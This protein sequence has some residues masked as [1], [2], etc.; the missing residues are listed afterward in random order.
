MQKEHIIITLQGIPDLKSGNGGNFSGKDELF[1]RVICHRNSKQSNHWFTIRLVCSDTLMTEDVLGGLLHN[2]WQQLKKTGRVRRRLARKMS[3]LGASVTKELSKD[4]I[5]IM[6]VFL[7]LFPPVFEAQLNRAKVRR[8]QRGW[9]N[10]C[11]SFPLSI[12]FCCTDSM[13]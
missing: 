11:W 8:T 5:V 12:S 3:S 6:Y 9:E 1:W 13:I 2:Q 10:S 4:D 7:S